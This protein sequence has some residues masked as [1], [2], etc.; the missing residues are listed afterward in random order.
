M[1]EWVYELRASTLRDAPV[2]AM[3]T[4]IPLMAWIAWDEITPREVRFGGIVC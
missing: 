2:I 4:I 3:V 1:E